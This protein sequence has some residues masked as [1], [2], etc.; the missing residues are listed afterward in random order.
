MAV[1]TPAIGMRDLATPTDVGAST[2][3]LVD[4]ELIQSGDFN[5]YRVGVTSFYGKG[6]TVDTSSPFTVVTQFVGSG[7]TLSEI[8]RFYV[9][10]GKTI[11]QPQ[12][13]VSGLTGNS[14]TQAWCDAENTAFQEDVYPFNDHGGKLTNIVSLHIAS[15]TITYRYGSSG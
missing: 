15:L 5:P 8:K 14:I 1:P 3:I 4:R 7:S 13:T 10:N 11:Q 9:Q 12:P 2:S 6:K